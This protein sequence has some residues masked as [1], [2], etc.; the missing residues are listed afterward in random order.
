M[1]R[2]QRREG[3]GGSQEGREGKWKEAYVGF[4]VGGTSGFKEDLGV[5]EGGRPGKGKIEGEGEER[6]KRERRR[7][8]KGGG[9]K[10][11][12]E[13]RGRRRRVIIMIIITMITVTLVMIS[14]NN[15]KWENDIKDSIIL[16]VSILIMVI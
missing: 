11:R 6:T 4:N 7:E 10:G 16:I 13:A 2:G 8:V 14:H 12:E 5:R 1:G 9:W 15:N 3:G